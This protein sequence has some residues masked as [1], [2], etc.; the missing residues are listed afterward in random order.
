MK[1]K[2]LVSLSQLESELKAAKTA[3]ERAK[4]AAIRAEMRQKQTEKHM[5]EPQLR[6]NICSRKYCEAGSFTHV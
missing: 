4:R 1:Q 3:T 6:R 2:M 5:E